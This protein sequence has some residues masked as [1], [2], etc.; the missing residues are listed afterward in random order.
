MSEFSILIL[1]ILI[2]SFFVITEIALIASKKA[3]LKK[4]KKNSSS[5]RAKII[6]NVIQSIHNPDD[7]ISTIQVCITCMS[8]LIGLIGGTAFIAKLQVLL[9]SLGLETYYA[10]IS[11]QVVVVIFITYL[12][13]LGEIVPKRIALQYPEKIITYT[14]STINFTRRLV[15]PLVVFLRVS[16]NFFLWAFRIKNT[17]DKISLDELKHII[18]EATQDGVFEEQSQVILSRLLD[19]QNITLGAIMTPRNQMRYLDAQQPIADNIATIRNHPHDYYP[20]I[21]G[22]WNEIIGFVS[23]KKILF[24]YMKNKDVNLVSLAYPILYLPEIANSFKGIKML[25]KHHSR[26]AIVIDEYGEIEGVVTIND[27]IK[28][29][30]GEFVIV[31]GDDS[32]NTRYLSDGSIRVRGNML[33]SELKSILN[34]KTLPG[35]EEHDYSTLSGFITKYLNKVPKKGESFLLNKWRFTVSKMTKHRIDEIKI[36]KG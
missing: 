31:S 12:T 20:L 28:N 10:E 3:K 7:Y 11:S 18:S 26:I 8:I 4:L 24:E 9:K 23:A 16:S 17:E 32:I 1:L 6:E 14:Y 22:S 36:K 15:L 25:Q 35:E 30:V 19:M 5:Y 13:V 21:N 33:I 2:N 27:I 29:F 34:L